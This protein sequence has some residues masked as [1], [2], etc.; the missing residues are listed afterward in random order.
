[1]DETVPTGSNPVILNLKNIKKDYPS[2]QIV[3]LL[4]LVFGG[5]TSW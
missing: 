5:L 1:M 3:F 4:L 2:S